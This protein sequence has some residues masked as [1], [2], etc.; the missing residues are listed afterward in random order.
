[1][2]FKCI[3]LNGQTIYHYHPITKNRCK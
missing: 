1:M 2:S 3:R